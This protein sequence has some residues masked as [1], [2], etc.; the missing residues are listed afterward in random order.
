[1][2]PVMPLGWLNPWREGDSRTGVHAKACKKHGCLMSC[3]C[4]CHG[5]TLH[6]NDRLRIDAPIPEE[7]RR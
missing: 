3:R 1:M 7:G 2:S 4:W 6:L 5:I